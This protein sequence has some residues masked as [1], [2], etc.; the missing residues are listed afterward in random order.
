MLFNYYVFNKIMIICFT[1]TF[2]TTIYPSPSPK[3]HR[4]LLFLTHE[5][6]SYLVP[7]VTQFLKERKK[8]SRGNYQIEKRE[9]KEEERRRGGLGVSPGPLQ[10]W[11]KYAHCPIRQPPPYS[12]SYLICVPPP[13][14]DPPP[15]THRPSVSLDQENEHIFR[16]RTPVVTYPTACNCKSPARDPPPVMLLQSLPTAHPVH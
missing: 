2:R 8:R 14:D 4:S 9:R 13:L 7:K 6:L 15:L 11:G 12:F 1:K 10:T 3:S 16:A 5:L